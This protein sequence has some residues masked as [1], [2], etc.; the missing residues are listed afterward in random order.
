MNTFEAYD[1]LERLY[2]LSRDIARQA[3]EHTSLLDL[4][5][6]GPPTNHGIIVGESIDSRNVL[7]GVREIYQNLGSY[8]ERFQLPLL[9]ACGND[10]RAY[11][12]FEPML[13]TAR[14]EARI[15]QV[16]SFLY[17]EEASSILLQPYASI[18]FEIRYPRDQLER[19][20]TYKDLRI[21]FGLGTSLS[22]ER[23]AP[24]LRA[25]LHLIS[26]GREER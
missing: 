20:F 26:S 21:V 2:G 17:C 7:N 15:R 9:G 23:I 1:R 4:L 25:A 6:N 13:S 12:K 3:L 11:D 16:P 14:E 22:R 10:H 5:T 18:P 24:A 8:V 19:C